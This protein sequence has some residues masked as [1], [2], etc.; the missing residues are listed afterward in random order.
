MSR[1]KIVNDLNQDSRIEK[2]VF[3]IRIKFFMIQVLQVYDSNQDYRT[4]IQNLMLEF[5][6][7]QAFS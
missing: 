2:I 3:M 6:L 5:D 4:K 1:V 7:S